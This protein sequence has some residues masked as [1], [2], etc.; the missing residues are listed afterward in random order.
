M[1]RIVI[2][3]GGISGLSL[4]YRLEQA[5]P[6]ATVTVLE[7]DSRPGG[8]IWTEHHDGFIVETGPNGFLDT[9]PAT[10]RLCHDLGLGNQLTPASDVAA[11]N[12]FLFQKGKLRQLPTSLLSFLQSDIL[13]WRGKVGILAERF[14][15][16]LPACADE[17]VETFARR[18]AGREI[19]E[20]L[21]DAFVTG[22]HAG[23]P[24][25]LS[26]RA[27][28]P[29]LAAL[30]AQYGSVLKGLFAI[31]KE[32]R[33]AAKVKGFAA[34]R[35]GRLWSFRDGLRLLVEALSANLRSPVI[36]GTSVRRLDRNGGGWIVRGEGKDNW[37]ADAVVLTCPAYQQAA[38]LTDL[39]SELSQLVG[40]I[41]YNR[42][43][44]VALGYRRTDIP[45]SLDG[46]GYLTPRGSRGDVLGVQW[47]SSSYPARAP[48]GMVLLRAICGGWQRPCV[49]GWDDMRLVE[50]VAAELRVSL[51]I[52]SP[53][54]FHRIVRWD[55][56]IPQYHIGHLD[57]IAAVEK[58]LS[59][60]PGLKLAGNAYHGVSMNDCTEQAELLATSLA[61]NFQ[62]AHWPRSSD[63]R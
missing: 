23:D 8:K 29:L 9:K 43:A 44:V 59:Q 14:R 49:V 5:L 27:A 45:V 42:V 28:F 57:R 54:V 13:S 62:I 6:N 40:T 11:R 39:D 2:V 35:P 37:N 12:R 41:P 51:K 36:V 20:V 30:E 56:A 15:R 4:A 48:E 34:E 38:I 18:R 22:I 33:R 19:A 21:V 10:L 61:A 50:T 32:R 24:N 58:R 60:Y 3:G 55:R 31:A 7:R 1:P 26:V 52:A 17:S 53:P 25:L 47:C 63:S 46:F 16:S